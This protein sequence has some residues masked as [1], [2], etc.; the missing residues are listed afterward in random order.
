M[1][2]FDRETTRPFP[3]KGR[4]EWVSRERKAPEFVNGLVEWEY[5]IY[6]SAADRL[7]GRRPFLILNHRAQFR[8]D[9]QRIVTDAQGRRLHISGEWVGATEARAFRDTSAY[10]RWVER[11]ELG[12]WVAADGRTLAPFLFARA[13]WL[14]AG[15]DQELDPQ[16]VREQF[17]VPIAEQVADAIRRRLDRAERKRE[18]GDLRGTTLNLQVS[19]SGDDATEYDTTLNTS[20]TRTWFGSWDGFAEAGLARFLNA[21]IAAGSTINSAVLSL[22]GTSDSGGFDPQLSPA[23]FYGADEDDCAAWSGTHRIGSGVTKTTASVAMLVSDLNG[24]AGKNTAT[25]NE[26]DDLSAIVQEIVDRGGWSS[27]NDIGIVWEDV[28]NPGNNQDSGFET[29]DSTSSRAPKLDI[30]YTAPAGGTTVTPTT[31]ALTTSTFAPQANMRINGASPTALSIATFAPQLR[32]VLTATTLALALTAFE[33]T[34]DISEDVTVTP[35][36]LALTMSLFAPQLRETLTPTLVALT[37]AT[38]APQ[39]RETLTPATL[40]LALSAF[41]PQLREQLTPGQAELVVTGFAPQLRETL[42]PGALALS[43]ATFAPPLDFRITGASPTGLVTATFAPSVGQPVSVVP[44]TLGLVIATFAPTVS[45]QEILEVL[46]TA[47]L[48]TYVPS[49]PGVA[50]RLPSFPAT[51]TY[52]ANAPGTATNE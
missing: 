2:R 27:G 7:Q 29:Y 13:P 9:H 38:F 49:S 48:A 20:D 37:L 17:T 51:A 24:G 39:L 14:S 11:N 5:E 35:D 34:I 30:D 28:T 6:E 33:P 41:A 18:F 45:G 19:A 31:L 23:T 40:A 12:E 52:V 8:E 43:L 44:G 25:W 47:G 26:T 10:Y 3:A 4:V 22:Y 36:A 21:T 32:E 50:T 15:P 42:T 1:S 16:W 46:R